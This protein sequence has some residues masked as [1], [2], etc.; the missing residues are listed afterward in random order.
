MVALGA[1]I[2][3]W[4]A[5]HRFVFIVYSHR[6]TWGRYY[7]YLLPFKNEKRKSKM[8]VGGWLARRDDDPDQKINY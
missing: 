2:G 6:I 8:P 1:R 7:V 5:M 3:S 4:A